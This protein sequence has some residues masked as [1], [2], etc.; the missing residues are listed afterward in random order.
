MAAQ[1]YTS[2]VQQLYISYFGRPADYY[3]LQNFSAQLDAMKAP[4]TF[5]EVQAAVQ[6]DKAGTSALSKLVNT[7]NN[8]AESNALYGTD[9]S[10]IGISKFVAAIYQNVLGRE[11]DTAGFNFWV[12]AITSGTLTKAN[13][14]AA[15]TAAA[16]T[17]TSDQGKL[18]ALVVKN[19]LDVATAFTT[20]LDTPTEI[21]AYSGDVAAATA[22]GLLAGV[23]S[24]TTVTGYQAT[25]DAAITGMTVVPGATIAL[26]VGV[27]TPAGTAGDDI[28]N[29]IPQTAA[30]ADADTLGAFDVIDGGA[31]KDTLNIYTK[32]GFNVTQQ[33]TVKNVETINIYN[34]T[35]A[36]FASTGLDA[37]KFVGA[38]NI[39]QAG[40]TA[41]AVTGLAATTTATFSGTST[42]TTA[43]SVT[44]A[45]GAS[46]AKVVL[47]GVT[48]ETSADVAAVPASNGP[49]NLPGTADDVAAVPAVVQQNGVTVNVAGAALSSVNLSGTVAAAIPDSNTSW[50]NL[51]VKAGASSAGAS[52]STVTVNSAL[53][54]TLTVAESAGTSGTV[55]TVD[56]S[57][58]TGNITYVA[59]NTVA[60]V[61]TGSGADRVTISYATAAASG[62]DAA[63]N[64]SVSTG[65]GNDNITILTTGTGLTTVDAG[66]GNDTITVTKVAG[67]GLNINGGEGNDTVVLRGAALATTDVIDGGAGTDTISLAGAGTRTADDF[68]VFNKLLK[69]FET[70]KFTSA[71]GGTTALDASLL[72]ANYT[73]IDLAA[74]STV[75]NVG[76]QSIVANGALTVSASGFKLDAANGNT[77]A[78]TLNITEKVNGTVNANADV[79]KLAVTAG[80]SAVAATLAGNAQ[81]AIVTLTNGANSTGTADTI[82]S[83]SLNTGTSNADLAS[84]TLSGNGS[85]TVTN[86]NGSD[87]VTVDASALGGKLTLGA[88]AGTAI[89]GLTYVSSNAA[90]ETIKLGAGIDSVTL[91]ASTYGKVD[92]V[93]GLN[94][95]LTA[96]GKSLAATSDKLFITGVS[97]A[98]KF[99]TAQTDFDLALKEAAAYKVNGVDANTLVFSFGGDTYVYQDVGGNNTVDA[100]DIVVKLTGAVNLDALVV[101]FTTPAP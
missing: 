63:K 74:G 19:K 83:V 29:A 18:D 70:I 2:V 66:A 49:D 17:N 24:T 5:A 50:V 39:N 57:A 40:V 54:T 71:E 86:A 56:A 48:G 89:N 4:K 99:T 52:V 80:T 3:G 87:L 41:A 28:F 33:G 45:A 44:A 37:S 96:D 14:A 26:T 91:N 64:A 32:P 65:A 85:A 69:N 11:A 25:I 60:N 82:A 95:V 97:N 27:D 53:R 42:D 34:A 23:T 8:S 38:T 36:T 7:F 75:A 92:T 84:L 51:N 101:A 12:N 72:G 62:T 15:I 10:Q 81:S 94:L 68:I 90:V 93:T 76:A 43:I 79:V 73:T 16:M 100:N 47:S 35:G 46:S 31:G 58:S 30:G 98:V 22:R 55:T 59:A 61:S 6:A 77:Y 21:N 88:N 1:D 9:N 67:A 20:A 78:G 13:A